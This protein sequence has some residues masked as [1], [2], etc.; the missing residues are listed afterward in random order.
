[1]VSVDQWRAARGTFNWHKR[2]TRCV[3]FS[4]NVNSSHFLSMML[5]YVVSG[6]NIM[7]LEFLYIFT[8]L[9][10]HGYIESNPGPKKLKPSY[11]SICHW[12][13]NSISARDS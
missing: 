3:S 2:V 6:A 13:L 11:L 1:M 10:C 8:F 9:L 5:Y 4:N 12:D 7:I